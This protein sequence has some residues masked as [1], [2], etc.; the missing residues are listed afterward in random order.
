[1]EEMTSPYDSEFSANIWPVIH[2]ELMV[3]G[4]EVRGLGISNFVIPS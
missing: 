1:M 2:P 3:G 4:V